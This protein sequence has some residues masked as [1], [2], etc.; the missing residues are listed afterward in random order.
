MVFLLWIQPLVGTSWVCLPVAFCVW[1]SVLAAPCGRLGWGR[2][3]SCAALDPHAG[4][5]SSRWEATKSERLFLERKG[6]VPW[7]EVLLRS[8]LPLEHV[9]AQGLSYL[10]ARQCSEA[11]LLCS[12]SVPQAM[13][14]LIEHAEDPTID[15]PLPGP[16]S[17]G[18]V[19]AEAAPAAGTSEEEEGRDELTEIFRKIRRRREFRADA[20]VRVDRRWGHLAGGG[21]GPPKA[22]PAGE[23]AAPRPGHRPR[24]ERG[25]KR[26]G[27]T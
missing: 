25:W 3:F 24:R 1:A 19:G 12:M 10:A 8:R 23:A 13:E 26:S 4:L 5:G 9:G 15:S 11:V 21:A 27:H 17:Q 14:W 20:R 16:A 6:P 18:E 7:P 2:G 22:S